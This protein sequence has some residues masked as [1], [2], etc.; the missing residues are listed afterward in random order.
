[1]SR[2]VNRDFILG[3]EEKEHFLKLLRD[4]EAFCGV[5]IVTFCIMTNH[6]HILVHETPWPAGSHRGYIWSQDTAFCSGGVLGRR[7]C[8]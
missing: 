7:V 8:R 4:Y 6:F 3:P 1:M 5:R 2:V